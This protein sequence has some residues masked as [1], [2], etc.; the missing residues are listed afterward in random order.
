MSAPRVAFRR[1][2]ALQGWRWLGESYRMYRR[3]WALWALFVIAYLVVTLCIS[4]LPFLGPLLATILKP[5]FAVG[6]LAA[7]W[8]QER[9]EPPRLSQLF[10]GFRSNLYALVPVGVVYW[11]GITLALLATSAGD[12]GT[13]VKFVFSNVAPPE[14]Y[15][16]GSEVQR[17]MLAGLVFALPVILALW[18]APAIVVFQDAGPLDALSGSLRAAA[19]NWR[20]LLA[21]GALM[22]VLWGM[23]PGLLLGLLVLLFGQTG[24]GLWLFASVPFWLSLLATMYICDYVSYRDVFHGE[25]ASATDAAA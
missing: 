1:R 4:A 13:L 19:E 21:F 7:A 6:F 2:P 10:A 25:E 8:S 15:W 5:V 12:G 24:V 16:N 22:L 14:D 18:F 9:G 23:V 11:L 20:A 17:A 3:Y